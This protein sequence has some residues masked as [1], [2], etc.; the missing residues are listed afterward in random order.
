MFI[1]CNKVVKTAISTLDSKLNEENNDHKTKDESELAKNDNIKKILQHFKG[2][3]DII[4]TNG[5][6]SEVKQILD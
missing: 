1:G 3:T 4:F 2:N 5:D 6:P